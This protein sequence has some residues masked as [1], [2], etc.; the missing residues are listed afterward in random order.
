MYVSSQTKG[1]EETEGLAEDQRPIEEAVQEERQAH[2]L[3]GG[4]VPAALQGPFVSS[5][6]AL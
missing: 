1:A 5:S 6:Q 3:V 2:C 4:G